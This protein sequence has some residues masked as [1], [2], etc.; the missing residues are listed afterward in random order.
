MNVSS[1]TADRELVTT[2]IFDAPREK[3]FEA[4]TNPEQVVHWWGPRGFTNT[5]HEMD[6]R[7]GGVW[8][9]IMHGPDGV[10]YQNL[11]EYKEVVRPEKLVYSHGSNDDPRQFE[12]SVTFE[13]EG[14]KTKL[15]MH[16][17][18][19]TAEEFKIKVEKFGAI[20]GLK[21]TLDR[22]EE[23]LAKR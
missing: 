10:D 3:V 13:E 16:S 21:G 2:R 14:S 18:F 7:P 22:L 9:F 4:W 8:K 23:Q 19:R 15:T 20:E 5:I 1:N 12:V 17:I 6:V 11:I